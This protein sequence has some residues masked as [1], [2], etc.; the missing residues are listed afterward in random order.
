M[1]FVAE[2]LELVFLCIRFAPFNVLFYTFGYNL[3]FS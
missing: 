3:Y 2:Q 1:E